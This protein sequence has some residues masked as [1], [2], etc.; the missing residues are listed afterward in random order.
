[1][2]LKTHQPKGKQ[3]H[4]AAFK[5]KTTNS[6][7]EQYGILGISAAHVLSIT[8]LQLWRPYTHAIASVIVAEEEA[9]SEATFSRLHL[10][11]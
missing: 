8:F 11:I 6:V 5:F 2:Y 10:L 3:L 4:P 1:M 7:T 9:R